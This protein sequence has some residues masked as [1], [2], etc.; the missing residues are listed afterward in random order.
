[1]AYATEADMR[2]IYTGSVLDRIAYS[3]DLDAADPEMI[4]RALESATH[5]INMYLSVAFTMP[6]ARVPPMVQQLAVD[7]AMYRMALT[8]D[9]MTT[10]IEDRYKMSIETLK[11]IAAGKLGLGLPD[12]NDDGEDDGL[13]VDQHTFSTMNSVLV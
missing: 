2:L 10:Q 8:N 5:E 3:R 1:M 13:S 12:R 9:K 6:L 4:E 11:M 7:I